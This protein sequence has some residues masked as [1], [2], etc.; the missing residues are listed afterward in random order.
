[1][2]ALVTLVLIISSGDY[3]RVDT[4]IVFPCK[5]SQLGLTPKQAGDGWIHLKALGEG[6]STLAEWEPDAPGS[7]SGRLV[8]IL[9]GKTPKGSK[10]TFRIAGTGPHNDP[11]MTA[12]VVKDE[13]V[14]LSTGAVPLV[15]YNHGVVPQFPDKA[16]PF[17]RACYFHPLWSPSG[18][19]LTGDYNPDHAHHRGLWFAWVKA[20]AGDIKANFWEIQ[21][22]QGKT[23]N[24][25]L[26]GKMFGNVFVGFTAKNESSSGGTVL[27]DETVRCRLYKCNQGETAVFDVTITQ[28]ARDKDVT[29][30]KIHY[31]GLG[32][33]GR[34]EWDGKQNTQNVAVLTSEG[35]VRKDSNATNARWFDYTGSLPKDGWGGVLV[36]DHPSNPR[37]PNRLRI[38]PTMCFGSSILVQTGDY[39]VRKGE[40][41]VRRYR[42]VLH[43]GKPD[44]EM[45]ERFAR[46]FQSPPTVTIVK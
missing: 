37:Y 40:P 31:G 4:P 24:V 46:D 8:F 32:L 29:L 27:L 38:H 9:P 23:R 18:E 41:L 36:I 42:F 21:R 13:H 6:G 11:L 10:R 5:L 2:Q 39:T 45:A 1:M 7:D 3:D 33:R 16:S 25:G 17:D 30:G 28:A 12:T 22:G 35:K 26:T 15:R 19:M 34:D 43:D 44:A 14:T 20:Q